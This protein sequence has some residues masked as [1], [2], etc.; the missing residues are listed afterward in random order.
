MKGIYMTKKNIFAIILLILLIICL[1]VLIVLNVNKYIINNSNNESN[2]PTN[3]EVDK[4]IM[5]STSDA[6][7]N[8]IEKIYFVGDSTTYHFHKAGVNKS[9]LLVPE[10]LTLLLD[11]SICDVTVGTTG[12][13]IPEAI[14]VNNA[15]FVIITLGVNGAD[16]FSE[17]SFKTY[18][19]KLIDAIQQAS[20]N[21]QIII[22]SAFP[23][24]KWFSDKEN[25]ISNNGIDRLNAWAKEIAYDK[26]LPYLD[27]Q[28]ILKDSNGAMIGDYDEGD[29]VHMNAD[30]YEQILDYIRTHAY[31]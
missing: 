2:T 31:Q 27:T 28:S 9:N 1:A 23:I 8:Y 12:L 7:W 20:P 16:R 5:A 11:S 13:T 10:S 6:G 14:K 22:Q 24:A 3:S 18:Y 30:A 25:G 17:T 21:T 26:N 19:N 15:E 29:G 4:V